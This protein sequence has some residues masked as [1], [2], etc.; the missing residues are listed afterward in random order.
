MQFSYKELY[1]EL[2]KL[3]G[4]SVTLKG[5]KVYIGIP[6]Y[7]MME[8][9][10]VRE[11]R[12][13]TGE[14]TTIKIGLDTKNRID[15]LQLYPRESYD[16]ILQRLLTILNLARTSPEQARSKLIV[17]DKQRKINFKEIK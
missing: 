2:Y 13:K 12:Q 3:N 11:K 5:R 16:D 1:S 17:L 7:S 15:H 14:N 9:G 10:I 8:E 4:L 6:G